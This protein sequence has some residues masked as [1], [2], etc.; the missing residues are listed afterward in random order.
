[1]PRRPRDALAVSPDLAEAY[2]TLAM[3]SLFVD[4]DPDAALGQ[5]RQAIALDPGNMRARCEYALS[6]LSTVAGDNDEAVRQTQ[7][8][9]SADGLNVWA[10][11]M[12]AFTNSI[13]GRI[14]ES[15]AAAQHA[16]TLARRGAVER[17]PM[18]DKMPTAIAR[19]GTTRTKRSSR[20]SRR[21]SD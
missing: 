7:K 3:I 6:A 15:L 11:S 12:H 10:W 1:M 20:Y 18:S 17:P 2:S 9:S 19:R 14:E 5:W 13:A 21:R 4:H 16:P 8:R